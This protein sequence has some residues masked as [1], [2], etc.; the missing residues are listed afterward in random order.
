MDGGT[1]CDS[2]LSELRKGLM[3]NPNL[4]SSSREV[5]QIIASPKVCECVAAE[6]IVAGTPTVEDTKESMLG[7]MKA[8]SKC[9][10]SS[11]QTQFPP[12]CPAIYED[13]L[14]RVGYPN[15]KPELVARACDCAAQVFSENLN[16]DT[17]YAFQ[18][19]QMLHAV[20]QASDARDGT[21]LASSIK[22]PPEPFAP[23]LAQV[24][25]CISKAAAQL[26]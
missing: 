26:Q 20:A 8:A 7:Y 6:M 5:L 24:R 17:L 23:A 4:P 3:S 22:V 14:P 18:S 11:L 13:I 15:P 12:K 9:T 21:K 10:A 16:A 1:L 2:H 19:Q 25:T